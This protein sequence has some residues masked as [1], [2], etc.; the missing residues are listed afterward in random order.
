MISKK[1]VVVAVSA[2][3]CVALVGTLVAYAAAIPAEAKY[4]GT[5]KCRLCHPSEHKTWNATKHASNFAPKEMAAMEGRE[6]FEAS[7]LRR[8]MERLFEDGRI[9]LE[10]YGRQ[11]DPRQR[12]AV[13]KP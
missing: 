8:A 4:V 9:A 2:M 11:G 6:G 5:K 10:K 12:I 1:A 3:T 13:V 7:D